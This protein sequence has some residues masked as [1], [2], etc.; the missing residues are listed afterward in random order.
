MTLLLSLCLIAFAGLFHAYWALG[1][2][3]GYSV[4]LPQR[5]DGAPVMAHRLGW[6][7]PAAGGIALCLAGL[8]W[9]LAGR[10]GYVPVPL[11][12]RLVRLFL[13]VVGTA[14]VARA[15]VP[16]R[17]VGLFKTLRGTRWAKYDTRLYSPLFLTLGLLILWQARA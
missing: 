8:G 13:L 15:L 1:G 7:R 11:P 12:E 6:W 10:E 2:R 3:V 16:N 5:E 14:F 17:Y 9:L 4:S